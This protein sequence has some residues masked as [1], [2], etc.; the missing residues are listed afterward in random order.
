MKLH[1]AAPS[2][3]V[4]KVRIAALELGLFDQIKIIDTMVAPGK[5]EEAFGQSVNPLRKIPALELDD[6][7]VIFDSQLI[8]EYLDSLDGKHLLFPAAGEARWQVLSGSAVANGMMDAAVLLRYETFLRPEDKRWDTWVD[9]QWVKIN[10][11]L[12]WFNK[13]LPESE[14]SVEG[15]SLACALGYLDFRSPDFEWRREYGRVAMWHD[16]ASA[17]DAYALT[18]PEG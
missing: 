18:S 14:T 15:I 2:P 16:S 12:A 9:E 4:R 1:Y 6:G 7:S 3:F 17:R 8:C 13:R 5:T 11:G 10:N